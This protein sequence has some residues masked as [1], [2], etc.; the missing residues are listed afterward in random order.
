MC[1]TIDT[2]QGANSRNARTSVGGRCSTTAHVGHCVGVIVVVFGDV[3][4]VDVDVDVDDDVVVFTMLLVDDIVALIEV[5]FCSN[6]CESYFVALN[7]SLVSSH[8]KA[9]L[10][11]QKQNKK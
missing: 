7:S 1:E 9:L 6:A 3:E 4:I 10:Q 5:F 11:K 8:K 2:E